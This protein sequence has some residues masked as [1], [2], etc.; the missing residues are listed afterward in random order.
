MP[1]DANGMWKP[2]SGG[3]T[4]DNVNKMLATDSP[5]VTQARSAGMDTANQ[6]GLLNSSIAAGASQKAAYDAVTPI[7]TADASIT[8]QKDLSAQSY[9]QNKSIQAD[10]I[11]STEKIATQSRDKDLTVADMNVR[12]NAQDKVAQASQNYA[13]VYASMVNNI[14][15][16]KD[17]PAASRDIYLA[18]AKTFYDNSMRLTEQ[19]YNVQL[20][21][22]SGAVNN[23]IAD[24]TSQSVMDQIRDGFR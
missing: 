3:T 21:W 4:A 1:Y 10:Q 23:S 13:S 5:F 9:N 6:R 7:A 24:Q 19:T 18:N 11:A 8:A 20:N 22:G 17:I 14:N 12:S 2:E 16:N 15:A